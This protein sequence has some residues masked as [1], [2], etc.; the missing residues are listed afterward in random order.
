[1]DAATVSPNSASAALWQG[2]TAA[3]RTR[4]AF[5][6][7]ELLVVISAITILM[8]ILLPVLRAARERGRRAACMANLRSLGQAIILYAGDNQ[9]RLVPGD[10]PVPW[11]VWAQPSDLLP[12]DGLGDA[13]A[14]QVNLGHL[15]SAKILPMPTREESVLFCPSARVAHDL[16]P[17]DD[18]QEQWGTEGIAG[19]PYMYNE[20]LDGFGSDVISGADALLA[21]KD[22]VNF[23]RADGSAD[24]LS[25]RA[26]IYDESAGPERL[27]EVVARY[28][29]CFATSMVFRWLE[30]GDVDI[31]EA[32]GYLSDPAFWYW[33]NSPL[34]PRRVVRLADVGSKPLV[35]D[36]VGH[37]S[38][39]AP[40]TPVSRS[41]GHG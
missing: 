41:T 38:A 5:T 31:S 19:I 20:A 37:P 29:I 18:L 21:H 23:V 16:S 40:E 6:L 4:R 34:T 35:S 15:L 9:D 22:V 3:R 24:R 14:R 36:I 10:C 8:A 27:A 39:Y 28:G 11:A 12:D 26:S 2:S 17:A 1:M 13:G 25:V 33:T 30:R 7:V 32:R